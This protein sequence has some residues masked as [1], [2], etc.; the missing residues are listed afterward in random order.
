MSMLVC[1]VLVCMVRLEVHWTVPACDGAS[2]CC[3]CAR[4]NVGLDVKSWSG[5]TSHMGYMSY[6][7]GEGSREGW[8]SSNGSAWVNP[9]GWVSLAGGVKSVGE[10]A[11]LGG[12]FCHVRGTVITN[13]I[14][15][16]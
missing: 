3:P 7:L 6:G 2:G 4:Q 14:I 16:I 10:L 11:V 15:C 1:G 8:S 13:M 12:W 5:R 9:D